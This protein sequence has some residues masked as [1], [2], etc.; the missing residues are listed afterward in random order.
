MRK[1]EN[2]ESDEMLK[3]PKGDHAKTDKMGNYIMK[4]IN[5]NRS[6][7]TN[8]NAQVH[9]NNNVKRVKTIFIDS[10]RSQTIN[11]STIPETINQ[12]IDQSVKRSIDQ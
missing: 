8:T 6:K 10:Q 5:A 1:C 12:S 9:E 11:H 4:R 7:S 3:S 2:R